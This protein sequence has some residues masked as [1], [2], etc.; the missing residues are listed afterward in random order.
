MHMATVDTHICLNEVIIT[1]NGKYSLCTVTVFVVVALHGVRRLGTEYNNDG[2]TT[3]TTG[4][5]E[6]RPMCV[7]TYTPFVCT[8]KGLRV[9][10][11]EVNDDHRVNCARTQ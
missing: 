8:R 9:D 7:R 4:I 6:T 11:N 3:V 1:R 5:E 10:Q 2:I